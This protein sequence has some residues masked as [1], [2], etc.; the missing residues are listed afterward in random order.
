MIVHLGLGN[1]FRAHQ[2]WYT[3]EAKD[4]WGIAAFTGRSAQAPDP[5][6]KLVTRG[7][8]SDEI[9][10]P[11]AIRETHPGTD[12]AAWERLLAQRET[13]VVTLTVTEKAYAGEDVPGRLVAGLKA[14]RDSGSGPIAIV[15]CD[16]LPDNGAVT[17]RVVTE[18]ARRA[19]PALAGWITE[20]VSF[21][22]TMVDRITPASTPPE[23]V[24]E[25]Y[26]E[27]VLQGDFPA[28]RPA[29]DTVGARFV[30]DVLPHEQRKLW[31]LNG[32]HSLLAYVGSARGLT[33]VAEAVD[34]PECRALLETWW[35][36]AAAALPLPAGEIR[37]YRAALA[38]RWENARIR[39]L[40][41]QIAMDGSQKIPIRVLPVLRHARENGTLP[42]GAI[43]I[44]AAWRRHLHGAGAP[45]DDAG[46][47]RFA[48]ATTAREFLG[49]LDPALAA[50]DDL[51]AAL[52]GEP[53][54]SS[55]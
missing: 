54:V 11:D 42:V 44:V 13:A 31:L 51:V 27:W 47:A 45:V 49:L 12:R 26:H 23:V 2:A 17:R 39:H 3:A 52:D 7:P 25:P 37:D 32:G 14:R 50:D 5:R 22:S 1:F 21:V 20:N 19:D 18:A 34:D 24:T 55:R 28:G 15:P 35:D 48:A 38:E 16:N 40:L 29:W 6:Y 33:T 4:G 36:E 9:S 41:A 8:E 53:V 43:G 10:W 46:A 30:A